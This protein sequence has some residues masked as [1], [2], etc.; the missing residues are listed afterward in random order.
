MSGLGRFAFNNATGGTVTEVANYRGSGE[1]W[2]VH[3]FTSSGTLT[4]LSSDG[5]FTAF[6]VGGGGYGGGSNPPGHGGGGGGGFGSE[7]NVSLPLPS[8]AITVGGSGTASSVGSVVTASAGGGGAFGGYYGGPSNGLSS[9]IINGVNSIYYGSGG[10]GGENNP[11]SVG[12]ANTARGGVGQNGDPNNSHG[13]GPGAS[14][15]V[16]IAYRII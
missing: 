1:M 11:Y 3:K 4:I 16:V 13:P 2:R 15:I 12:G 9:N 14:G 5:L 6:V 7:S 8:Y 10:P